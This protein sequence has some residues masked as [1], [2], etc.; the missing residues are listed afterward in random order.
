[1]T[2]K[3]KGK[4]GRHKSRIET[5]AV[6]SDGSK[7]ETI[8]RALGLVPIFRYEKFRAEWTDGNGHLVL[9]ETPI[10]I[11][12]EL[13]GS[14]RWIDRM[15]K[16]LG[17]SQADYITHTYAELFREWKRQTGSPAEEM[18]FQAIKRKFR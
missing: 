14:S 10:G 7:A 4:A 13:E 11:Y 16:R 18:T 8:F 5:E 12:A 9:D 17:L 2:H 3:A 1:V 15:A 6:L